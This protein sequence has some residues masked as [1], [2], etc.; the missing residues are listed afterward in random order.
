M[1]ESA[2]T[3]HPADVV[4]LSIHNTDAMSNSIDDQFF[5]YY[6]VTGVPTLQVGN[7]T[8]VWGSS[9]IGSA[10]TST[11]S[12]TALV[13]ACGLMTY[14]GTSIT[15]KTQTKFFAATSGNYY[16]ATYLVENG[17]SGSQ[18]NGGTY[19]NLSHK[20]VL[21]GVATGSAI[22]ELIASG[23]ITTGT[24]INKTYTVTAGTG[25]NLANVYLALVIW[26]KTGTTWTFVNAWQ[27]KAN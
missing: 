6:N 3:S 25:W 2:I 1:W 19:V 22:G 11:N 5:S 8:N 14:T 17:V 9:M 24:V 26:Q 10:V 23:N 20:H 27:S 21:R 7:Q 16:L 13:N 18:N 4:P 15:V 12:G